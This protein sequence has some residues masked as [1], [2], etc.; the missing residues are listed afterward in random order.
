MSSV[1][2]SYT[3]HCTCLGL[4]ARRDALVCMPQP[5]QLLPRRPR[6]RLID[7]TQHGRRQ[8]LIASDRQSTT[9]W[10]GLRSRLPSCSL[11]SA[12]LRCTDKLH[13]IPACE[14]QPQQPS[15]MMKIASV[16][17]HV[18]TPFYSSH[19]KN[20]RSKAPILLSCVHKKATANTHTDTHTH[21]HTHTHTQ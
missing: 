14:T 2:V 11:H 18:T 7:A 21:T 9:G 1:G 16:G 6:R 17:L 8:L 20:A 19:S 4:P 3:V 15:S 13:V 5:L 10:A 12:T